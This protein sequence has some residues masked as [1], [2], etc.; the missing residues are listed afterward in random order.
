MAL[1]R[2]LTITTLVASLEQLRATD[3]VLTADASPI[4]VGRARM[5]VVAEL[6]GD[7][8]AEGFEA[9]R[10]KMSE[11][12][13]ANH[14]IVILCGNLDMARELALRVDPTCWEHATDLGRYGGFLTFIDGVNSHFVRALPS[15]R[16]QR[17]SAA[18]APTAT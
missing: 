4:S 11:P 13:I 2:S 18:S 5:V 7:D 16:T 8:Y 6:A 15:V 3:V 14:G 9:L 1:P 17:L 10:A 12:D